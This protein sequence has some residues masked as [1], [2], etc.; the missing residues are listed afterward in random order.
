MAMGHEKP[1]LQGSGTWA[2]LSEAVRH[3]AAKRHVTCSCDDSFCSVGW[4]DWTKAKELGIIGLSNLLGR[5][6]CLLPFGQQT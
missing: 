4:K 1:G 2:L 6:H 5:R 3:D